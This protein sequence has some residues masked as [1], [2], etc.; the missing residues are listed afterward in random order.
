MTQKLES[1][2]FSKS[3]P[4]K[5]YNMLKVISR[6]EIIKRERLIELETMQIISE[7]KKEFIELKNNLEIIT[8]KYAEM[9]KEKNVSKDKLK[10]FEKKIKKIQLKIIE[11]FKDL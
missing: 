10:N 1:V 11:K 2:D 3:D 4:R 6:E 5:I 7:K 8:Q 9:S